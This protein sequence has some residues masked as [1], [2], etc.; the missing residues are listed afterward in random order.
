MSEKSAEEEV[1]ELTHV[2]Q[3]LR[4]NPREEAYLVISE[5]SIFYERQHIWLTFD[6]AEACPFIYC[7]RTGGQAS[8][9]SKNSLEEGELYP[10]GVDDGEI[11]LTRFVD[12]ER[13]PIPYHD[14]PLVE[15]RC[16][17][18]AETSLMVKEPLASMPR[19]CS[20]CGSTGVEPQYVW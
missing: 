17:Y 15:V 8:L 11:V 6:P 3:R 20:K 10:S 1:G 2:A 12:F 9:W 16:P 18:C 4:D 5:D 14:A 7:K 13:T 19:D